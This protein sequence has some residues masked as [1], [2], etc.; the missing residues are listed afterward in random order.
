MAGG[1][2]VELDRLLVQ[3]DEFVAV[4]DANVR[5]EPGEVLQ[6]SRSVWLRQDHHPAHHIGLS[7]A[8]L[9][10]RPD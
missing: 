8:N 1:V 5:I 6:L 4:R 2:S 3:F 10:C 7:G 9:R